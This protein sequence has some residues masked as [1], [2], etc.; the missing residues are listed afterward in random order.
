MAPLL[1][2]GKHHGRQ[3]LVGY[4]L[5][6]TLVTDIVILAE[7]AQ[8]VTVCEEYGSGTMYSNKGRFFSK[9]RVKT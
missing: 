1:L 6:D 7:V 4:F 2:Q 3:L 9:V 8:Q 5:A